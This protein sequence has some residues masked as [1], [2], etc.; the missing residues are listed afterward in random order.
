MLDVG[1]IGAVRFLT[2]YVARLNFAAGRPPATR[3]GCDE[4]AIDS[5]GAAIYTAVDHFGRS[6][7]TK[8]ENG[9]SQI[10]QDLLRRVVRPV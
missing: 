3:Q 5:R 8:K 2:V 4:S 1:G 10:R 6:F 9:H 7:T